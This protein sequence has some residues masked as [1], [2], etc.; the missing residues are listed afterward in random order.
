M[1][2][3]CTLHQI[4]HWEESAFWWIRREERTMSFP[5]D[6]FRGVVTPARLRSFWATGVDGADA[7]YSTQDTS[8]EFQDNFY[9]ER[10]FAY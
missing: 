10:K 2:Y 3:N 1:Y 8:S 6:Y 4:K 9:L 7:G 5:H